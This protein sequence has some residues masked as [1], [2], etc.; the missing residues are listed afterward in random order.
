MMKHVKGSVFCFDTN[1]I[2]HDVSQRNMLCF[3]D[4]G[5]I[6]NNMYQHFK[7]M[8]EFLFEPVSHTQTVSRG[9]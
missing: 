6:R 8:L 9:N 1:V 4:N 7:D 5:G 3:A 2:K